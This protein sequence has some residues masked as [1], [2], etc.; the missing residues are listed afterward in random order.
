[1]GWVLVAALQTQQ[2]IGYLFS[3][4]SPG[5][6]FLM[7]R[8]SAFC[9]RPHEID[10]SLGFC[11]LKRIG[12]VGAVNVLAPRNSHTC[13]NLKSRRIRIYSWYDGPDNCD[14]ARVSHDCLPI[15]VS[16]T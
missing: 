11:N 16:G 12:T 14:A 8:A 3:P 10:V 4:W 15:L 2:S 6:Q 9:S 7:Y 13:W 5:V 1:M